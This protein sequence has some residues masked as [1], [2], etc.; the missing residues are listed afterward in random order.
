MQRKNPHQ[1]SHN[2]EMMFV[3]RLAWS[4]NVPDN[5][6]PYS[7]GGWE[8]TKTWVC[9][10]GGKI[11]HRFPFKEDVFIAASGFNFYG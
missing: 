1:H 7:S 6:K 4:T 9:K 11:K 5:L 8:A 10:R 3:N 2:W